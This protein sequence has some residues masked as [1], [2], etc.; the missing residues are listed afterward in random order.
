MVTVTQCA[1]KGREYKHSTSAPTST[2]MLLLAVALCGGNGQLTSF[3]LFQ[4]NSS[5]TILAKPVPHTGIPFQPKLPHQ[6]TV[7]EPFTVEER[8]KMMLAQK[9]EKIKQILEEERRV[10]HVHSSTQPCF[11]PCVMLA[12]AESS[13]PLSPASH[14]VSWLLVPRT[15]RKIVISLL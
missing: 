11:S 14:L 8:S 1:N 12:S 10:S 4:A 9:E 13:R 5:S 15:E 2:R 6:H 3:A 7:P